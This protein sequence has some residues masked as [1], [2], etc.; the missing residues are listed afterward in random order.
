MKALL[1]WPLELLAGVLTLVGIAVVLGGVGLGVLADQ[2]S[3]E[4]R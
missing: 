1:I 4:S 2:L 3:Q